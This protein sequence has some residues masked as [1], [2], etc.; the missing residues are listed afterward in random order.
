MY[1]S[2]GPVANVAEVAGTENG[3]SQSSGNIASLNQLFINMGGL[4]A[5]AAT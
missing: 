3:N 1:P 4:I 2:G 5:G